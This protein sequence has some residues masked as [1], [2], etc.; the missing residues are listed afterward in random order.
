MTP[1]DLTEVPGKLLPAPYTSSMLRRLIGKPLRIVFR[2][3]IN[4]RGFGSYI[5]PDED[6]IEE[7]R[8]RN[9]LLRRSGWKWAPAVFA[10]FREEAK[11]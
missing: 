1:S 6:V 10:I 9:I 5:V 2:T 7:V 8:G 3:D 11:S 4:V